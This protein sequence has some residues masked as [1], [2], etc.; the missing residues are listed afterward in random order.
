MNFFFNVSQ[1]SRCY[2]MESYK[3]MKK[4]TTSNKD[5]ASLTSFASLV[6]TV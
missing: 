5:G 1:E 3:S 4:M 2:K 6:A